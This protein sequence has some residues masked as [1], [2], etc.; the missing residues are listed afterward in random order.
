MAMEFLGIL[1]FER[2]RAR[3]SRGLEGRGV[4]E[5]LGAPQAFIYGT[6]KEIVAGDR[7]AYPKEFGK[8]RGSFDRTVAESFGIHA[9]SY[10]V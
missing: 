4:G 1:V 5:R 8:W 3:V 7:D 6:D 9:E 10:S 2:E